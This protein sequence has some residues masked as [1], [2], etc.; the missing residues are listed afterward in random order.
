M[1]AQRLRSGTTI[2]NPVGGSHCF[3]CRSPRITPHQGKKAYQL[4]PCKPRCVRAN[5]RRMYG[6]QNAAKCI[7]S[8]AT[9]S[10]KFMSYLSLFLSFPGLTG[11]S[12]HYSSSCPRFLVGHP[13]FLTW[14]PPECVGAGMTQQ[15]IIMQF[16]IIQSCSEAALPHSWPLT[17]RDYILQ[18]PAS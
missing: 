9:D 3:L 14:I 4:T 12:S 11:E 13:F 17:K 15:A 5:M 10:C 16:S 1:P 8:R 18:Y 7:W 2:R 6:P